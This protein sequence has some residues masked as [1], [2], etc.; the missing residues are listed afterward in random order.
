MLFPTLALLA[1]T[2]GTLA[3]P[4]QPW[5]YGGPQQQQPC[6]PA[7]IALATGIHLNIQ[8]QYSEYNGTVAIANLE[9]STPVNQTEFYI[10]KGELL[11]DI[12]EGMNLRLFNQQIA[13][14]GNPALPGLAKYQ[15]AQ[16]AEQT[17]AE[18]LTG[19]PS[20]DAT[21]LS[22]LK[23]D[24]M[25]GIQLNMQNLANVSSASSSAVVSSASRSVD[26]VADSY[27]HAGN[28]AVSV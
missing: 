17:L 22:T 23:S 20:Q 18:D 15:A 8:G 6:P 3:S 16:A 19:V 24:I 11:S 27:V 10:L 26:F 2:V 12:Q 25:A 28:V 7:V 1:L 13:P 21:A 4:T 9:A 14:P 5:N